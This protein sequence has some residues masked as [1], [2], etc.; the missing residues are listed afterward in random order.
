MLTVV[1]TQA[2]AWTKTSNI[3]PIRY[4]PAATIVAAWIRAE[5]G[6][7][8]AIASGSHTCS[9]NCADL[10]TVPP[11]SRSA[12]IDTN[13]GETTPRP[14]ISPISWMFVVVK[15][16]TAINAMMP[17]MNGTSP[18]RVVMNALIAAFEFSFSS[19]QW[20]ISR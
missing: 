1:S 14:M 5:T 11:N 3:R 20:P 13:S 12:A 6:V 4:T 18:I 17:N 16:V 10:P 9:G 15:P 19:H 8:P 7:G 2:S